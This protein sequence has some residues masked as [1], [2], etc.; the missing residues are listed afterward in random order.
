[1]VLVTVIGGEPRIFNIVSEEGRYYSVPDGDD[2]PPWYAL[3]IGCL[4][5]DEDDLM[6]WSRKAIAEA[7]GKDVANSLQINH[8]G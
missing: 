2:L 5:G 7:L 6:E 3:R 4:K 1:M 8:Y